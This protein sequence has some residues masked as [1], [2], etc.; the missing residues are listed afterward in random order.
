MMGKAPDDDA[1]TLARVGR[2]VPL[3]SVAVTGLGETY[4]L[5]EYLRRYTTEPVRFAVGVSLLAQ[6][7]DEQFYDKLPGRLLEGLGKVFAQNIKV[8]VYPMRRDDVIAALGP[9]ANRFRL[10]GSDGDTVTAD[11]LQPAPPVDH[12]YRYLRA[13]G[14]VMPVGV[15]RGEPGEPRLHG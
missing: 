12:L 5:A 15:D 9:R 2:L 3:C 8:H 6:V 13:A 4:L 11:D 7:L 14:L 1:G 10:G